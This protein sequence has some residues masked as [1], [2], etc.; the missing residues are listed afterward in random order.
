MP[1]SNT[2]GSFISPSLS[3]PTKALFCILSFLI[4]RYLPGKDENLSL[5]PYNGLICSTAVLT[6]LHF[7]A[8]ILAASWRLLEGA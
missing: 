1:F 5:Q 4:S 7:K 2:M 6:G 3:M 8:V